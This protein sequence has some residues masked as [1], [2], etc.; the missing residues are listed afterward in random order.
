MRPLFGEPM[1]ATKQRVNQQA[2]AIRD[3]PYESR[4]AQIAFAKIERAVGL[5]PTYGDTEDNLLGYEYKT[6]TYGAPHKESFSNHPLHP[7]VNRRVHYEQGTNAVSSPKNLVKCQNH[8]TNTK[9]ITST[10]PNSF[11]QSAIFIQSSEIRKPRLIW[12]GLYSFT[13]NPFRKNILPITLLFGIFCKNK[14]S[15]VIEYKYFSQMIPGGGDPHRENA[16]R[17]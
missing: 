4:A 7:D 12:T 16:T 9:Q 13:Y 10:L 6:T 17:T 1:S 15:Y 8:L 2:E 14:I 3:S 11:H 5:E